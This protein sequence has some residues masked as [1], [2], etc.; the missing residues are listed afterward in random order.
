MDFIAWA[1]GPAHTRGELVGPS[2]SFLTGSHYRGER[3][4]SCLGLH[5]RTVA[6]PT[7]LMELD[8]ITIFTSMALAVCHLIL[9][10]GV[11]DKKNG[12]TI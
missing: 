3:K 1:V 11:K 9:N 12:L 7:T 10:T 2:Y 4:A 6:P 5:H 8:S